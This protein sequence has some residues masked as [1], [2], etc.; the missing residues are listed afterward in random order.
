M[1]TLIAEQKSEIDII[2]ARQKATWESGDFG[3]VAKI[4][5]PVA[6]DFMSR[7][8]LRP[9]RYQL[10]AAASIGSLAT[11]GSL[12]FDV[13]VPDYMNDPV[14]LSGLMLT[15]TP[16][17]PIAPP[18]AYRD[19]LPVIPTTRR[20]FE[21]TS[22]VSAFVRIYQGGKTPVVACATRTMCW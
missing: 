18:D 15:A 21:P 6:A 11:S 20:T 9:G 17:V 10:R 4:I 5:T 8:N 19:L 1:N 2:K 22:H 12:Y 7:L 13:D 14:S 3:Q 16:N